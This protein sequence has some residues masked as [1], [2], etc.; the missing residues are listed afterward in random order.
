MTVS[1]TKPL[2]AAQPLLLLMVVGFFLSMPLYDYGGLQHGVLAGTPPVSQQKHV[3]FPPP[4]RV[5]CQSSTTFS[6]SVGAK[7]TS[8]GAQSSQEVWCWILPSKRRTWHQFGAGSIARVSNVQHSRDRAA[9]DVPPCQRSV[10]GGSE[11]MMLSM[12]ARRC[13]SCTKIRR[14]ARRRASRSMPIFL[15]MAPSRGSP[16]MAS[17]RPMP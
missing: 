10:L 1:P 13:F 14:T 17:R 5:A 11:L 6:S 4:L 12:T 7:L 8:Q 2:A 16:R 15:R 3:A 9:S